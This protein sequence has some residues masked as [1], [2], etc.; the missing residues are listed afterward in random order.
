MT[1]N[2]PNG[3]FFKIVKVKTAEAQALRR[4]VF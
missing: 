1:K 4:F 2:P 3:G